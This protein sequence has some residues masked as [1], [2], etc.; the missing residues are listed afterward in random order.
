MLVDTLQE[1]E[2]ELIDTRICNQRSWHNGHVNDN[3]ICAGFDKGGV[4][5]CQVMSSHY[6]ISLQKNWSV[7]DSD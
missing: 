7:I 5:T 2:V 1:A 6:I 3:M 4:D